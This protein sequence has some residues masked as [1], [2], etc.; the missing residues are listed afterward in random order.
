MLTINSRTFQQR[1]THWRQVANTID[2]PK[3]PYHALH[4]G[5]HWRQV[6]NTIDQPKK[7][8]SCTTYGTHWRQVANTIDQ[9][10]R[11]QQRDLLQ[12]NM[13]KWIAL[14]PDYELPLKQ[15]IHSSMFYISHC[16]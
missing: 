12:S 8:I 3:E 13:L 10:V 6:A 1:G 9:Y 16:I 4:K 14:G 15:S 2:Q 5:A 7:T 11:R